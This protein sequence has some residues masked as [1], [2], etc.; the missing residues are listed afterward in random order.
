[1][2]GVMISLTVLSPNFRMPSS[3]SFSSELFTSLICRALVR[4]SV[5][6]SSARLP[7]ALRTK[8]MLLTIRRERGLKSIDSTCS[9]DAAKVANFTLLL[10]A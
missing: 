2:R 7:T 6:I 8:P 4:S 9:G 3:Q 1:M 10:V 5:E